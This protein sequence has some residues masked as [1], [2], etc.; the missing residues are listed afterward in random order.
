MT[1]VNTHIL[2]AFLF[3]DKS[4]IITLTFKELYGEF[5]ESELEQWIQ[6]E[7]APGVKTEMEKFFIGMG[8]NERDFSITRHANGAGVSHSRDCD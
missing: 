3:M 2:F 1:V 7:V 5:D 6:S 8:G 4:V